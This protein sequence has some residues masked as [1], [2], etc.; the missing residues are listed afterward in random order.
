MLVQ[1]Q[2]QCQCQFHNAIAISIAVVIHVYGGAPLLAFYFQQRRVSK[3][4]F[5]VAVERQRNGELRA[6][7][8][9]VCQIV[10]LY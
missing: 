6:G 5:L 3:V 7:T 4:G 9:A 8:I 2:S 10:L 1:S